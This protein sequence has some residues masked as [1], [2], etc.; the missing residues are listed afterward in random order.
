LISAKTYYLLLP[1]FL[2]NS[3]NTLRQNKE[4]GASFVFSNSFQISSTFKIWLRGSNCLRILPHGY[5][6]QLAQFQT[7]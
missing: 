3:F 5:Y 7:T 6:F 4:D 2:S 1:Y